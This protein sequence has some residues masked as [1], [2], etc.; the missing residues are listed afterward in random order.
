M[1][2]A[3]GFDGLSFDPFS[4]LQDGLT[5]P[6]VDVSRREI[7]HALVLAPEVVVIEKGVDLLPEIARQV[8]VLQQNAVLQ[9]LV[10][11]LDLA[12]S[13]QVK[14]GSSDMSHL[15]VF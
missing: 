4:A 8:V 10:P 7:V 5:A 11:P 14:R 15:P 2:Q 13:L 3:L 9:T 12:L 6:E 1:K